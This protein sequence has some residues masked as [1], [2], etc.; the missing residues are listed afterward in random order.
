MRT[1]FIVVPAVFFLLASNASAQSKDYPI[2]SSE[3]MPTVQVTATPRVFQISDGDTEAISGTYRI[4]NGW[5]LKVEPAR[6]G[7]VAQ[8]DKQH[9]MRLIALSADKFVTADGNVAMEFNRGP[10]RDSMQMSYVPSSNI[11]EVIVVGSTLAER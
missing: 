11:A 10:D 7:I 5:R 8:I 6:D 1:V 3:A 9:K 2:T 4:S